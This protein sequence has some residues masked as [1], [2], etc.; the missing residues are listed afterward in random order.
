[1]FLLPQS[2]VLTNNEINKIVTENGLRSVF[3]FILLIYNVFLLPPPL[4]STSP[5]SSC[6]FSPMDI[7]NTE[8]Y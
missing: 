7:I 3:F 5:P 8:Q 1:M 4:H 6:D 2:A